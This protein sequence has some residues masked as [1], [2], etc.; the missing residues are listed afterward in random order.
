[1][2]KSAAYIPRVQIK[3]QVYSKLH[4][5]SEVMILSCSLSLVSLQEDND[6]L[7]CIDSKL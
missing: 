2:S 5:M 4:Y 6:T 7:A 1:M 3:R